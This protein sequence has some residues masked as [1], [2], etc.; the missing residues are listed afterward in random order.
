MNVIGHGDSS[1]YARTRVGVP[2]RGA[3]VNKENVQT[4]FVSVYV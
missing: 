4:M 3:Y 1:V 2:V